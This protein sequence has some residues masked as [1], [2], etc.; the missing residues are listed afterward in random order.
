[1]QTILKNH[2]LTA[3]KEL[4]RN[5]GETE[6]SAS[7]LSH[8]PVFEYRTQTLEGE[9]TIEIDVEK[10]VRNLGTAALRSRGKKAVEASGAVV[11]TARNIREIA[12]GDWRPNFLNKN[13]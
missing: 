12:L 8:W 11:V 13:P 2:K 7:G 4:R 1:M 5:T 10:L 3:T 6:Y 9:I